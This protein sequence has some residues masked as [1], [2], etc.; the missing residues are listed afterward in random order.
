MAKTQLLCALALLSLT[1]PASA[2]TPTPDEVREAGKIARERAVSTEDIE[3]MV[4]K[5][6]ER[7]ERYMDQARDITGNAKKPHAGMGEA[8]SG[9]K[10]PVASADK[11]ATLYIFISSS[12]PKTLIQQYM[13]DAVRYRGTVVLRGLIDNSMRQTIN[14]I[15]EIV[16]ANDG[17]GGL[18]I[19]PKTF[20]VFGVN[21]V[22]AIVLAEDPAELCMSQDCAIDAPVFDKV[23][24]AISV[25]YALE[26]FANHGDLKGLS[27]ARLNGG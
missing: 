13:D 3:A 12:M 6:M 5:S 26:T 11:R 20:E 27:K 2:Q 24:G 16:D 21:A 23:T 7:A 18:S 19:D 10:L 14:E 4:K 9:F 15:Q 1:L 25:I 8:L 17:Q 22:P